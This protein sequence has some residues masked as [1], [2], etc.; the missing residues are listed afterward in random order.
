M[1]TYLSG[2][3]FNIIGKVVWAIP[4]IVYVTFNSVGSSKSPLYENSL[5]SSFCCF[6]FSFLFPKTVSLNI[7]D[8]VQLFASPSAI[9][10]YTAVL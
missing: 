7:S 6:N 2:L 10:V 4:S 3:P 5:H 8:I 1:T 9:I